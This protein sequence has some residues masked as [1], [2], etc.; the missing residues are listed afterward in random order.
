MSTPLVTLALV[1]YNHRRFL[2]Q[3]LRSVLTQDYP[4]LE[5]IVVDDASTDDSQQQIKRFVEAHQLPWQLW[6]RSSNQGFCRN[7]NDVLKVATGE[8]LF[9]LAADDFMA[10]NRVSSLIQ[11]LQLSPPGTAVVY[12]DCS[13]VD[14]YNQV[15][16]PSF[17]GYYAPKLRSLPEGQV[18]DRLVQQN[19]ICNTAVLMRVH[20]LKQIGG[21]DEQLVLED[22]GTWLKLADRGF[23]FAASETPN[24]CY[25]ILPNS[26]LRSMGVRFYEDLFAIFS[27]LIHRKEPAVRQAIR[28]QLAH[29]CKHCYYKGSAKA[30]AMFQFFFTHFGLHPK[31]AWL[32]LLHRWGIS[33]LQYR[34]QAFG[35]DG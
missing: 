23:L 33:G 27:D 35:K 24:F 6:L 12:S 26:M 32:Y 22:Y 15:I 31:L 1:C 7:L 11:K 20:A 30:G 19:F 29:C 3:A 13:L 14:E 16:A 17:V 4:A 18:L 28:K 34:K 9:V 2:E 25:R 8:F 21:F 10:P 5:V